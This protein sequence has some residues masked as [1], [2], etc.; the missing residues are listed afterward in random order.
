[1][2]RSRRCQTDRMGTAGRTRL[3]HG[4]IVRQRSKLRKIGMALVMAFTGWI[5]IMPSAGTF[6]DALSPSGQ[7]IPI[8]DLPGWKQIFTSDFNHG[9][10]PV[11]GFP[12][13]A[14]AAKWSENYPDGTP[15]TAGQMPGG[16]SAYYPS[17][18]L[19]ISNGVL[20][21]YLHTEN[22]IP[23]GAAPS[24]IIGNATKSPYNSLLYG[25]Y[26]VRFKSDALAGFKTAWLLW[27]D[28]GV[29]PRDG[30]IDYPEQDLTKAFYGA[31]H[32]SDGGKD[33]FETIQSGA[34]FTTWHTATTEW[35]PGRV[36]FFLDG[37]SIGVSTTN[38]PHTPMHYILQTESCL[39]GCPAPSTS[40]H[41]DVDWVAIWS[42]S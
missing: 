10:V 20:D 23:M 17:K 31:V 24:P 5:L 14:Y 26:S 30:E 32:W 7:A 6:A 11:G 13:K 40:G 19:S 16:K 34:S 42:R 18:V 12:G 39:T 8:G 22:G 28:S 33:T 37:R 15:D 41:L 21:M 25:R 2:L 1:M 3:R 38:V 4:G 29:W 9:N 27:P 36:E 35:S